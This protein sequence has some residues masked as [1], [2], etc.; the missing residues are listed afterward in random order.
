VIWDLQTQFFVI[1]GLQVQSDFG[2]LKRLK[3]S[4]NAK[5]F[6][7]TNVGFEYAFQI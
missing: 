2:D 5:N 1:S 4:A 6:L 3:K 7:F